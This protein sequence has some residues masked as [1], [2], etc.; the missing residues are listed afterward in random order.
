M[1]RIIHSDRDSRTQS[2]FWQALCKLLDVKPRYTSSFHPQA[3]G[4]AER[5]NQNL[6]IHLSQ[7]HIQGHSWL[8]YLDVVELAINNAPIRSSKYSPYFL[9]YGFHPCVIPD[10]LLEDDSHRNY[11]RNVREFMIQMQNDWQSV[12][13]LQ[14]TVTDMAED[15]ANRHRR[16]HTFQRWR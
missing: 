10:V 14:N 12:R 8:C 5:T 11:H 6:K 1:D 4:Q 3:N 15:Q 2:H 13:L 16:S 7:L 9:N